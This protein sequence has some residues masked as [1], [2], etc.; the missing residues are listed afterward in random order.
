MATYRI[1]EYYLHNKVEEDCFVIRKKEQSASIICEDSRNICPH[2]SVAQ[3]I[4]FL[5]Q[6]SRVGIPL[7]VLKKLKKKYTFLWQSESLFLYRVYNFKHD[8]RQ[9]CCY[10][11]L[12]SISGVSKQ[13]LERKYLV[14]TLSQLSWLEQQIFNLWTMSS[15]LIESTKV[16]FIKVI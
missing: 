10:V 11:M 5:N 14:F 13:L 12:C 7:E 1:V 4:G 3:S 9:L 15:N 8:T 6:V 2:S 16:L